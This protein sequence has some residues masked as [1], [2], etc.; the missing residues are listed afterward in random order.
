MKRCILADPEGVRTET[1]LFRGTADGV[2]VVVLLVG[3]GRRGGGV[4]LPQIAAV[5]LPGVHIGVKCLPEE[6]RSGIR[7]GTLNSIIKWCFRTG[8][9]VNRRVLSKLSHSLVQFKRRKRDGGRDE[10]RDYRHEHCK[11]GRA[12]PPERHL[13]TYTEYLIPY[14]SSSFWS[15]CNVVLKTTCP[16]SKLHAAIDKVDRMEMGIRARLQS[17]YSTTLSDA[18]TRK[19]AW[20]DIVKIC[21]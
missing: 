15:S 9:P 13:A 5:R 19:T 1:S 12:F 14:Q 16:S 8:E 7:I 18:A 3:E 21:A 6:F 10:G 11:Q 17:R 20:N 2:V 4:L